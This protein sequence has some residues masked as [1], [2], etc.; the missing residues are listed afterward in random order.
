MTGTAI[1]AADDRH[2]SRQAHRANRAVVACRTGQCRHRVSEAGWPPRGGPV[3]GLARAVGRDMTHRILANRRDTMAGRTTIDTRVVIRRFGTCL[4][5]RGDM[6]ITADITR[7][8]MRRSRVSQFAGAGKTAAAIM[9]GKAGCYN[10]AVIHTCRRSPGCSCMAGAA[11]G[12]GH[13]RHVGG[14]TQAWT[15]GVVMAGRTRRRG[16][17]MVKGCWAPRGRP[18][19]A[20]A[21][22]TGRDMRH[23]VFACGADTMT[24]CAATGTGIVISRFGASHPGRGVMAGVAIAAIYKCRCMTGWLRCHIA[25]AIRTGVTHLIVIYSHCRSPTGSGTIM[26]TLAHLA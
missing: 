24:G 7:G 19:T 21:G 16:H 5:G 6:T 1:R 26:A 9:T 2:V 4:P 23:R 15:H 18:V 17:S 12:I 14:G 10:L 22:I 8:R 11:I 20:F 3:A 13:H 25:V